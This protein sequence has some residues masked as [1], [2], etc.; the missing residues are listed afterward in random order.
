[1]NK[2]MVSERIKVEVFNPSMPYRMI[3]PERYE[4]FHRL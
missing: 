2:V 3:V 4:V 1:M